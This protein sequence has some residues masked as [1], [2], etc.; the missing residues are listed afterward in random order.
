MA[1]FKE[2]LTQVVDWLQQD[3]RVSDLALKRQFDLDEDYLKDLK[4]A[5]AFSHPQACD[6]D[7]RGLV[8]TG[9]SPDPTQNAQ[10]ETDW[11]ISFHPL[12]TQSPIQQIPP[13][14]GD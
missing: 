1:T 5:L 4:E 2:V 9:D 7:D 10:P 6:E 3:G 13:L 11:E 12:K 8:W 14:W